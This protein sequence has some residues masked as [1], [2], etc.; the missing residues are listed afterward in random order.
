MYC[1]RFAKNANVGVDVG[2]I[3]QYFILIY[4]PFI[5]GG[6]VF[7]IKGRTS[8]FSFEV[9]IR[10]FLFLYT[11]IADSNALIN[12]CFVYDETNR[13]GTSENGDVCF[14]I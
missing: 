8:T 10:C 12:L 11:C 2:S 1:G 4:L 13:I 14:L 3:V 5:A 7:S 6:G 9:A